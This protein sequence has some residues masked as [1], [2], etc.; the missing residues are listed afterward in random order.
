MLSFQWW[1]RKGG[2]AAGRGA[3]WELRQ[4]CACVQLRVHNSGPNS[5]FHPPPLP[6]EKLVPLVLVALKVLKDLAANLALLGPP[7]LLGLL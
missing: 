1:G 2:E 7:D 4:G 3:R 6:R 5:S